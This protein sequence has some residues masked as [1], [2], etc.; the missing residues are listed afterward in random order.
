M[1]IWGEEVHLVLMKY[2]EEREGRGGIVLVTF[3]LP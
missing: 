3:L 1:Q 2:E